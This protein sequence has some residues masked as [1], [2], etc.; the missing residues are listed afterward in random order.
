MRRGERMKTVSDVFQEINEIQE[1]I[2]K[3]DAVC[4]GDTVDATVVIGIEDLVE[5]ANR[6]IADLY[7]KNVK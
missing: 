7:S 5:Y 3:M 6:Y 1:T 2:R 4:E